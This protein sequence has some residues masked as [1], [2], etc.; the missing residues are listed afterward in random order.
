MGD[1][2]VPLGKAHIVKP[3]EHVTVIGYGGQMLVLQK[4]CARAEAELG[5]LYVAL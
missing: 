3:G 2:T 4:A 1:Y 5:M